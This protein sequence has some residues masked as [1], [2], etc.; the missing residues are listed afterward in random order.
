MFQVRAAVT[1]KCS[2]GY[3]IRTARVIVNGCIM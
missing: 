1:S 3:S 2:M